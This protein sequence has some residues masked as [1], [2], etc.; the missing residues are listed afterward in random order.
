MFANGARPYV[1]LLFTYWPV[2]LRRNFGNGKGADRV[3]VLGRDVTVVKAAA[4]MDWGTE[5]YTRQIR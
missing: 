2:W 4:F 3:L 1:V 5:P